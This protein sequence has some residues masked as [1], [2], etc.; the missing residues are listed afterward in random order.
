MHAGRV[1]LVAALL[2]SAVPRSVRAVP[3]SG[4]PGP[5]LA[6]SAAPPV[7]TPWT[8]P[9][10]APEKRAELLLAQMTLEE[11]V[12]LATGEECL[13]Y[14]FY[15]A[16][17]DRLGIPALTMTDGPAGIR[18]PYARVNGGRATQLPA[19]IAL[20]ATWDVALARVQGDLLGAEAF[21]TGHNVFLGPTLDLAREPLAGRNFETFGEDPLLAARFAVP[22]IQ[23]VQSHPVLANG[24]H[25]AVYT[26]EDD[27]F[28]LDA[29]ID[30]RAL[31]EIYLRPFQA[32]VQDADVA[33]VMCGFNRI[34]GAFACED[35]LLLADVLK[36]ELG[37][38]GFV[39]SDWGGTHDT[40]A[41]ATAGLDQELAFERYFG[42]RLFDAVRRGEVAGDVVDDKA[43]RILEAMFRFGLFERPAAF[44]PLPEQEDGVRSRLIAEQGVVLLA[45]RGGLLPL[46]NGAVRSIA[47]I[48]ADAANFSTQGGGAARVEPTYGVSA[49][50]AI[51]LRAG[52]GVRVEHAEGTDPVTAASLLPGPPT[53]PSSVLT[54][55]G[56]DPASHGLRAEY[57][58]T[59]GFEGPPY[60]VQVDRQPAVSAGFFAYPSINASSVPALRPEFALTR[61]SA[62]W[63]GTLTA[64]ATGD[65]TFTLTSR[66]RGWLFLD[67]TAIIDHSQ[68]H[69]LASRSASV[70]LVAGQ[71]HA[72]RVDYSADDPGIGVKTDLGG[73]LKLGWQVPPGTVAPAM[74]DAARLAAASDVAIV[75]ARDY[76]TEERDRPDLALPEAQDALIHE[77]AAANQRT[78]V[79]LSTG[80]PVAMPWLDAVG[81][82]LEVWYPGQEQGNV[83]ARALFGDVNPSGKLPVT[84]P[85]ALERSPAGA[86]NAVA[87][88][89][90]GPTIPYAEGILI[91]YRWYDANHVEPL[92]P[93][94]HGLSYTTFRYDGLE[95]EPA[96][97]GRPAPPPRSAPPPDG[98]TR[99]PAR[100]SFTVTNTGSRAGAEVAQVY[101]GSCSRSASAPQQLAGFAK[102]ELAPGASE[103][104][105]VEIAPESLAYWN[106]TSHAW[107][108]WTCDLPVY[109][110]SSSRDV[111]LVG[112]IRGSTGRGYAFGR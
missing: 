33:S 93:F 100:V 104:V 44:V 81:A 98:A 15:N 26:Q 41:A 28:T 106:A 111:R 4:C 9:S 35:R 7:S 91:G 43:R 24:K 70:H 77:V 84:F 51:R 105:A 85:A 52:P 65:Y 34:N 18:I 92:F 42:R 29:R 72:I 86:A 78:I 80:Q 46:S 8:D 56:A 60:L 58:L 53:V 40:V 49:L 96:A 22:F 94:G 67:G 63:T 38:R 6:S 88:G 109:V 45:N 36:G 69:D 79:V 54:P 39:L 16:P 87:P 95:V 71:P 62:R 13:V 83:I 102:V 55:A 64:P 12:D 66:G 110:G 61:F 5:S 17:I 112:R 1:L 48:G 47:V 19:P 50:A 2:S 101:V 74:R 68:S 76:G 99:P 82:V 25:Y 32:A 75:V 10:L 97:P 107:A 11:K 73:D 103:R 90:D 23:A 89:A 20:A 59:P 27:R 37:F 57:W 108:V 31:R 3:P 14:G 30:E 21:A